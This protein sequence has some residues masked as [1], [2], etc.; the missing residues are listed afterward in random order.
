MIANPLK[1]SLRG[2]NGDP[3]TVRGFSWVSTTRFPH[4]QFSFWVLPGHD[5]LGELGS[6]R[7]I[8]EVGE[9]LLDL[10]LLLQGK[11]LVMVGD[12]LRGGRELEHVLPLLLGLL[13]EVQQL[14]L[15]VFGTIGGQHDP[16][17]TQIF[18]LGSK[19]FTLGSKRG[20]NH[21]RWVLEGVKGVLSSPPVFRL[22]FVGT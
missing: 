18:T 17:S 11:L 20:S 12:L 14:V 3:N 16:R 2:Q 21:C 1:S 6:V 4:L 8:P 10:G 7:V 15:C 9:A 19:I 13:L 22:G 5:L